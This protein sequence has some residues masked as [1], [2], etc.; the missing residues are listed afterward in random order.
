MASIAIA[1]VKYRLDIRD[2]SSTV[3]GAMLLSV[4][5]DVIPQAKLQATGG[6]TVFRLVLDVTNA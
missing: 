1:M 5:L 3:A 2:S 6:N 4:A